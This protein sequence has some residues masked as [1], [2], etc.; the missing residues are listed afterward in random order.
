MIKP[1][2]YSGLDDAL[3]H[4]HYMKLA[5]QQA[6]A[7][8][9]ADE[10]PVGAVIVHEQRVIGA[11]HNMTVRLRDPT[12]HA[13]MMAITQAAE[14][15]GDWRLED[16]TLYATLEPCPMCAGAILQARIPN[17]VFGALDPKGGAVESMYTLLSDSRL[18]HKSLVTSGV[19]G[20]DCGDILTEFFRRK[21]AMGKK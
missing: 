1:N 2:D 18:N 7:A 17:V 6:V 14:A 20:K 4:E 21:R 8:F 9:E 12:A 5:M 16:C 10:V 13:E 3:P 19:F 11:A 15:I